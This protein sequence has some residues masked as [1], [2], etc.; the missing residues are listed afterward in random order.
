MKPLVHEQG[1]RQ[2]AELARRVRRRMRMML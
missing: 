2:L 1:R